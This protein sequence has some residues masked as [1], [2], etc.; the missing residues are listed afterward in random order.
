M[1]S[2][3]LSTQNTCLGKEIRYLMFNYAPYRKACFE[4]KE[5]GRAKSGYLLGTLVM[6][7]F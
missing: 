6:G 1:E 2:F 7:S 4:L 5:V 3:L